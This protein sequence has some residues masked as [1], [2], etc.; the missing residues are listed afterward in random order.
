[1]CTIP[2]YYMNLRKDLY[3]P[4][5]QNTMVIAYTI[6]ANVAI[7]FIVSTEES[8]EQLVTELWEIEDQPPKAVWTQSEQAAALWYINT[9]KR[10][11]I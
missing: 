11:S 10:N 9:T 2:Y 8:T 1:M 5:T 3:A 4:L 6:N 7:I